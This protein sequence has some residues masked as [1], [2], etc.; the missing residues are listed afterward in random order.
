MRSTILCQGCDQ[1]LKEA[2]DALRHHASVMHSGIELAE[3]GPT[4]EQRKEFVDSFIAS[5]NDVQSAWH[6]YR[7]HLAGHGLLPDL[8]A[9]RDVA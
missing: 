2:S 4:E 1:R 8:S 9:T 6:A 3:T 7:E 5:F